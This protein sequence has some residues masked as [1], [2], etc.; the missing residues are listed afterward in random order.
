MGGGGGTQKLPRSVS[1]L[2]IALERA[3]CSR[4]IINNNGTC[5]DALGGG[6]GRG[7]QRLPRSVSPLSIALER[8]SCSRFIINN[9]GTCLD[10]LGSYSNS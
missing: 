3:S 5:L 7:I 2:S 9:N 4:F 10:A 1:P 8:A 6:W